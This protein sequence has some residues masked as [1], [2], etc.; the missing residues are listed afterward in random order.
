MVCVRKLWGCMVRLM[1]KGKRESAD[2]IIVSLYFIDV[3]N[4]LDMKNEYVHGV[5]TCHHDNII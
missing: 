4:L 1:V 2:N 3:S 5:H